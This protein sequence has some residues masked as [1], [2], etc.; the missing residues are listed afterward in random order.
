VQLFRIDTDESA[1][2]RVVQE[3]EGDDYEGHCYGILADH[4]RHARVLYGLHNLTGP[5]PAPLPDVPS[6]GPLG[7]AQELTAS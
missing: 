3:H 7:F 1:L 5:R 4:G 2:Q 6:L